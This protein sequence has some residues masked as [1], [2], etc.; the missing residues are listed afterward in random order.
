[1]IEGESIYGTISVHDILNLLQ[2]AHPD[3]AVN[4]NMISIPKGINALGEYDVAMAFYRDIV[5]TLKLVVA[6]AQSE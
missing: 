3:V 1:M 2:E 6:D 4:K 5:A